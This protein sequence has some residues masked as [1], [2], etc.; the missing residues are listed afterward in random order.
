MNDI[1]TFNN[2][3]FGS[4]R[5]VEVDGKPHWQPRQHRVMLTLPKLQRKTHNL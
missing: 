4:I 2:P 1:K 3:E 5:T